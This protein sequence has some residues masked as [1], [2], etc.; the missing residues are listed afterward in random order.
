MRRLP[1]ALALA[2]LG[3]DALGADLPVR[4]PEPVRFALPFT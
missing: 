1:F 4:A 3:F 2:G